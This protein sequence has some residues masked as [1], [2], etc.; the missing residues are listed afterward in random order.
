MHVVWL[1][2][3]N[4]LMLLKEYLIIFSNVLSITGSG[5]K[6]GS[7]TAP[8]V[9]V[10]HTQLQ[11]TVKL[12]WLADIKKLLTQSQIMIRMSKYSPWMND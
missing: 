6:C 4:M 8:N 1:I 9:I 10:I 11:N 5:C 2:G 3:T 12:C 7:F